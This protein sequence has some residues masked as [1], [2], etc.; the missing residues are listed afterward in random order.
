MK[1]LKK[2]LAVLM[3]IILAVTLTA[4]SGGDKKD[5]APAEKKPPGLQMIFS[6]QLPRVKNMICLCRHRGFLPADH[7]PPLFLTL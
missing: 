1:N 7:L 4:C 5:A 3:M 2:W 6:P